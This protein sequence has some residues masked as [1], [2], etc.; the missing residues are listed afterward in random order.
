MSEIRRTPLFDAHVALGGKL[1]DF[2]G[3]EMPIQYAGIKA[4]HEAVRTTSG[5]FDVSHMGEVR[6]LGADA[7]AFLN[8]ACLNDASKLKVGRAQ[9]S[10][11]ANDSGGLIDDIYLYRE[12][13]TNFLVVC[14][15][16]NREAVV[17]HLQNLATDYDV[18]VTD[19]S[20]DWALIALQG[21]DAQKQL[22]AV[23]SADLS[24]LRKNRYEDVNYQTSEIRVAKTGYT[25]EKIGYEIF[26]RPNSA[27]SLWTA[28]IDAGATPC[29]LGARDTLRLEAG[30]PLFGHEFDG[31]TN[32][33]C[34]DY[35]WVV[36]DKDF[37]GRTALWQ[38]DCSKKLVGIKLTDKG[39]A[40]E[41][42]V[43]KKDGV[44][45]GTITSGTM[46]PSLGIA[47]A[48]AWVDVAYAEVNTAISIEV[49]NKEL[50]ALIVEMPFGQ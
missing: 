14:N 49:R 11:I 9:Y 36:K 28:L 47:I 12:A 20:D 29:G 31:T 16:S 21:P 3:W 10:M 6:V 44:E 13:D 48:M 32:P 8:F 25:G 19:E 17:P 37:F 46:S 41:G 22:E 24:A 30:F 2:A 35:A 1:V 50:A 43:V 15:A 34:S 4:E 38:P 18:V 33:L 42:Y 39:I 26:V 5:L 27:A 23:C 45:I 7:E 40:R